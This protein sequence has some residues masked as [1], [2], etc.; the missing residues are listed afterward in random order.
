MLLLLGKVTSSL[1]ALGSGK[2]S[3][4]KKRRNHT[5]QVISLHVL[6]SKDGPIFL[7]DCQGGVIIG[8]H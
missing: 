6:S 8:R 1:S 3:F 5:Q 2:V 7:D 4:A